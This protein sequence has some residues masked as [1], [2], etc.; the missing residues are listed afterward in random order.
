M[1]RVN[2]YIKQPFPTNQPLNLFGTTASFLGMSWGPNS[3]SKGK[4]LE[5]FMGPQNRESLHGL[6]NYYRVND[7]TSATVTGFP[8]HQSNHAAEYSGARP[9]V[10]MAEQPASSLHAAL[11]PQI[12]P[13]QLNGGKAKEVPFA[14]CALRGNERSGRGGAML[15]ARCRKHKQGRRVLPH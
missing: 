8:S 6:P 14:T 5:T 12:Q 2:I 3:T 13:E 15:C 7:H 4:D 11:A 1:T 9:T 10:T